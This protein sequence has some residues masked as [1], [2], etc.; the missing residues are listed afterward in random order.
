MLMRF[1]ANHS[2]QELRVQSSQKKLWISLS[3]LQNNNLCYLLYAFI[4]YRLCFVNIQ[5]V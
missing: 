1:E 3:V 2:L 5:D 4:S